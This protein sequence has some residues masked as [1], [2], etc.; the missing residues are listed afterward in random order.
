MPTPLPESSK[1]VV[2]GG[3]VHGLSTA[4]HLAMEL[5]ASGQGSG[6]DVILLDKTAP[7]AGA[8]GIACGCVR[9]LYMTEPLHAIIATPLMS[10]T[11]TRFSLASS[12]SA[13]CPV[14]K[15]TR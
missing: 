8:T 4:W 3:G 12:R 11:T 13:T 2:V 15:R 1:Y 9:N 14:V 5:E 10:G 6:A 7:G